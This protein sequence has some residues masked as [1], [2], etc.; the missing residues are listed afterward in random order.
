[1]RVFG[2]P[3]WRERLSDEE[4]VNSVRKGLRVIRWSRW[5]LAGVFIGVVAFCAYAVISIANSLT[6]LDG[7]DGPGRPLVYGIIGL[8]ILSGGFMGFWIGHLGEVV[9]NAFF[10]F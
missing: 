5:L 9:M 1:M 10:G 4:Y 3:L 6:S 2:L 8:A 7:K